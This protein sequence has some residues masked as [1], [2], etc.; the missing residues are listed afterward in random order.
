VV[1]KGLRSFDEHDADFFLELVPGPRRADGLPDSL[2]F[3]KIRIE[4]T[5]PEKTFKV[6]TVFGPSGCGK[7][8]LV[9]AGLLPRLS[10]AVIPIY[11]EATPVGTESGLLRMIRKRLPHLPGDTDLRTTLIAAKEPLGEGHRKLLM[12]ID[13]FEQWLH[14]KR[15][16]EWTELSEALRECDGERVQALV[17]VRDDFSMALF[18]FLEVL[19]IDFRRGENAYVVHRFGLPHARKVLIA[20]GRAY[21]RLPEGVGDLTR[22]QDDFLDQALEG[23]SQD[24]EIVSVR[25]AL[26]AEMVGEMLGGRPWTP[27]TLREIG[28]TE[29]VGVTFLEKTFNSRKYNPYYHLHQE[30]AQAVLMALLPESGTD[31]KAHIR[32]Y[33]ELIKLSGYANRP[34]DFDELLSILDGETRLITPVEPEGWNEGDATPGLPGERYYQLTH[35]YLVPSIREWLYREKRKTRRGRAELRLAALSDSWNKE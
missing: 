23:L 33:D 9:R 30:A 3:W 34:K 11:I 6:G 1:P 29:G 20:F 2:H 15:G 22:E 21:G 8:S 28:G 10:A 31:I 5:D 12:V 26:F 16:Q 18:R 13:Q 4:E 19:G 7:S 17:L 35:D 24:G 14:A 27:A 32:S 25:L